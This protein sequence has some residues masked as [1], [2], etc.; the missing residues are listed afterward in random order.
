MTPDSR[1]I[2][3]R[4]L[5]PHSCIS[6]R[7]TL[8]H[9]A[10]GRWKPVNR[11]QNMEGLGCWGNTTCGRGRLSSCRSL[12]IATADAVLCLKNEFFI[13]DVIPDLLKQSLFPDYKEI[14]KI[15]YFSPSL[16]SDHFSNGNQYQRPFSLCSRTYFQEAGSFFTNH[17]A[18]GKL[19]RMLPAFYGRSFRFAIV[20]APSHAQSLSFHV[21]ALRGSKYA[22]PAHSGG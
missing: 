14:T 3:R 20:T 17:P 19:R 10:A 9:A 13:F 12:E 11:Q 21:P 18:A 15:K 22:S 8:I 16:R 6:K 5:P 2:N 1:E 4:F 7:H